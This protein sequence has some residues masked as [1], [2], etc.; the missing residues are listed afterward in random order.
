MYLSAYT[1]GD[2]VNIGLHAGASVFLS[3]EPNSLVW[4]QRRKSFAISYAS[5]EDGFD[6][7][8]YIPNLGI[9]G[10]S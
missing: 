3:K 10:G 9:S 1:T 5:V 8:L 4:N 7:F 2:I 6:S